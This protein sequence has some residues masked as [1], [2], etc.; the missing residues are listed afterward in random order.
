MVPAKYNTK[1]ELG[2]EIA[3]NAAKMR[4]GVLTFDLRR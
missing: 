2:Q 1:T 3:T 4:Q